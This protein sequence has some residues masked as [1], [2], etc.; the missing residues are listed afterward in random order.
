MEVLLVA[1]VGIMNLACFFLG[2]KVGQA[3]ATGEKIETPEVKGPM[4][5]YREQREQKEADKEA[6]RVEKILQNI[7]IYDGTDVGQKDI[8]M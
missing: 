2:A 5:I 6:D 1:V 4:Q 3:T 7:E 8:P